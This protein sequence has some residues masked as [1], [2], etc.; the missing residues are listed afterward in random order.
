MVQEPRGREGGKTYV[1][2]QT[3]KPIEFVVHKVSSQ[4]YAFVTTELREQIQTKKHIIQ[5]VQQD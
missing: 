1:V 5:K 4:K 3:L 2:Q